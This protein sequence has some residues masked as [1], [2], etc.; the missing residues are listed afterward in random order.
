MNLPEN[1]TGCV[2]EQAIAFYLGI[3]SSVEA[4]EVI[5]AATL[6]WCY[7]PRLLN[8]IRALFDALVDYMIDFDVDTWSTGD[9][10]TKTLVG[11]TIIDAAHAGTLGWKD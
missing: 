4:R 9:V 8:E 3:K 6:T 10:D 1:I 5:D 7:E 2:A 11:L